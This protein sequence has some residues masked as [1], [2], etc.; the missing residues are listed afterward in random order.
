MLSCSCSEWDGEGWYWMFNYPGEEWPILKTKKRKRCCSCKELISI[1]AECLEFERYRAPLSDIEERIWGD[2]VQ[3]AS[4]Y[5][6][7]SCSEIFLNL[8]ALKYCLDITQKMT[9]AL[10]EYWELTGFKKVA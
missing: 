1:G 4:Y 7:L 10:A 5:M 6:C 9:E 2:E 8:D 3:I